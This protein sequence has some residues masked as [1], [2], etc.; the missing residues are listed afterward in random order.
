MFHYNTM[1]RALQN[2]DPCI[3][4][5][6]PPGCN[7]WGIFH[8]LNQNRQGKRLPTKRKGGGKRVAGEE[9]TNKI[10]FHYAT[11]CL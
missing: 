11:L 10:V 7:M 8:N 9:R 1:G 5:K 6:T 3:S 2:Q 4:P